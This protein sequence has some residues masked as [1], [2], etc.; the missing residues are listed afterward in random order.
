MS[1]LVH[2]AV[3]GRP[4]WNAKDIF[5]S[6]CFRCSEFRH[7]KLSKSGSGYGFS[8][9]GGK[10]DAGTVFPIYIKEVVAGSS[11][12]DSGEVHCGDQLVSINGQELEGMSCKQ[13][14]ELIRDSTTEQLSLT[15]LS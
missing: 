6:F 3:E 11:A 10:D 9:V 13:A 12:E 1:K 14:S 5:S 2:L 4:D 8:I 15:L 7:V